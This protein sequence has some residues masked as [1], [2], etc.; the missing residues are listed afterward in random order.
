M[1]WLASDAFYLFPP[2]PLITP[3]TIRSV[4][5]NV[6]FRLGNLCELANNDHSAKDN[7]GDRLHIH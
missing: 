4:R 1:Q 2:S 3:P 6:V 7:I 5:V